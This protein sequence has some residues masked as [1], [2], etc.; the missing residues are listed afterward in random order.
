MA[1]Y[2]CHNFSSCIA[3]RIGSN[4]S[5]LG[6]RSSMLV[7]EAKPTTLKR[8]SPGDGF[9]NHM[10]FIELWNNLKCNFHIQ[11]FHII[12]IHRALLMLASWL[13][14]EF[15]FSRVQPAAMATHALKEIPLAPLVLTSFVWPLLE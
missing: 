10:C 7:C 15:D 6:T 14:V 1:F 2:R 11:R 3:T 12:L 5:H 9:E 4:R 8:P 13:M